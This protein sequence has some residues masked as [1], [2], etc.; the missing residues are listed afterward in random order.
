MEGIH[1][2]REGKRD[3]LSADK[4]VSLPDMTD[5]VTE[6]GAYKKDRRER[7]EPPLYGTV[8]YDDIAVT[9]K[10]IA[11]RLRRTVGAQWAA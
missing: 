2:M 1:R 11:D 9:M 6:S 10:G 8:A 5:T 7:T 3:R 4:D